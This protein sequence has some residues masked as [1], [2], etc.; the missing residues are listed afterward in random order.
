MAA[1]AVEERARD[2]EELA[3]L[4][5]IQSKPPSLKSGVLADIAHDL[6]PPIIHEIISVVK[7]FDAITAKDL[8]TAALWTAEF[9]VPPPFNRIIPTNTLAYL[10]TKAEAV[11]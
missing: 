1:E 9:L 4:I 8:A 2:V 5:L 3:K 7:F 10:S 6:S 11:T